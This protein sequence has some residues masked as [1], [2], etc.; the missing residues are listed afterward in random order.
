MPSA[1]E[2]QGVDQQV[3]WQRVFK[4]R[5]CRGKG[6]AS[7]AYK[8][9]GTG[10]AGSPSLF[11][12]NYI[13]RICVLW[14]LIWDN[15]GILEPVILFSCG[16]VLTTLVTVLFLFLKHKDYWKHLLSALWLQLNIFMKPSFFLERTPTLNVKLGWILNSTNKLDHLSFLSVL[17]FPSSIIDLKISR[18][19][20]T[21]TIVFFRLQC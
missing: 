21:N 16:N 8:C 7:S 15:K 20:H 5:G 6:Q 4:S 9:H 11:F 10:P 1:L 3:I 2:E 12:G 19:V 18:Y 13:F 17:P 14:I